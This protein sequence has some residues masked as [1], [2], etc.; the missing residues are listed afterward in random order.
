MKDAGTSFAQTHSRNEA[1]VIT[2]YSGATS[3]TAKVLSASSL[4]ESSFPRQR[5]FLKIAAMLFRQ[6]Q[7]ALFFER[8]RSPSV[9]QRAL[10]ESTRRQRRKERMGKKAIYTVLEQEERGTVVIFY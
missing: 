3:A 6:V 2:Q 8:K 5:Y 9:V 1:A 7:R 4:S 10:L